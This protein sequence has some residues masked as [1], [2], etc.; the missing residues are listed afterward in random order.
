MDRYQKRKQGADRV[1]AKGGCGERENE[2]N[3]LQKRKYI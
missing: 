2:I 3:I 1:N